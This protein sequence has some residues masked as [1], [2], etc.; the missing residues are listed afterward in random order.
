MDHIALFDAH[1]DTVSR[2]C[3]KNYQSDSFTKSSGHLDLE[4][5]AGYAPYAQFFALFANASTAGPPMWERYQTMLARL[6]KEIAEHSRHI[7]ICCTAEQAVSAGQQ[8][9]AAAFVSVEGAELLNCDIQMLEQA[10]TDGVRAVT[11]T[12]NHAN[13]LSGTHMD[14]PEQGLTQQGVAFV[15]RMRELG[16]LVDVSHLSDPGFWDIVEKVPGPVIATHSNARNIFFHTRNLTDE[17]ITAI[18]QSQGVIG[19]NLYEPFVGPKRAT[20]DHLRAH[21][22]HILDLGGA[23]TVALGGDWDGADPLVEGFEDISCWSVLY[24]ELLRRNYPQELIDKLFYNNMMRI[25]REV[26]ST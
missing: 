7:C 10:Y 5:I 1:C 19:L 26:C 14:H 2:M 23:D 24:E 9:R 12:W 13:A 11:I 25:V 18:I 17:Q 16:M 3:H 22:D 21:L 8:G 6:R 4:R 15:S 20:V